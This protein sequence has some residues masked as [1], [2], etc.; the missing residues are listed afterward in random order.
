MILYIYDL[1]RKLSRSVGGLP[2]DR[3]SFSVE[4]EGQQLCNNGRPW[5]EYHLARDLPYLVPY[6]SLK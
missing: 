2:T 6:F 1:G 3:P 4:S 5:Y